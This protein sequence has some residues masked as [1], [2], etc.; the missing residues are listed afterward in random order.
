MATKGEYLN[1]RVSLIV[2]NFAILSR[3]FSGGKSGAIAYFEPLIVVSVGKILRAD[4]HKVLHR[5]ER[6]IRHLSV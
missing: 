3:N 5:T 6:G 2:F 4:G 1:R